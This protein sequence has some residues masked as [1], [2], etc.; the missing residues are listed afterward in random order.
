MI[1][2]S[3]KRMEQLRS[4][5]KDG[6]VTWLPPPLSAAASATEHQMSQE[7]LQGFHKL[8]Q[9]RKKLIEQARTDV[10][11]ELA[12]PEVKLDEAMV[13]DENGEWKNAVS[14]LHAD[15]CYGIHSTLSGF[16]LTLGVE[17]GW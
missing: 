10:S 11:R 15:R 7:I 2:N 5:D 1:A 6:S 12:D 9:G 8:T 13:Q 4:A 3:Q 14:S 17:R 16:R